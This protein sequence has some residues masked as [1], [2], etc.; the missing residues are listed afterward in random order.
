[1]AIPKSTRPRVRARKRVGRC[2]ELSFAVLMDHEDWTLVHGIVNG[3]PDECPRTCHAWLERD[4]QVFDPVSDELSPS[5]RYRI[6][7]DALAVARY[8]AHQAG[9]LA[10]ETRH[11]G[12]W[13]PEL[14]TFADQAERE[15]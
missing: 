4:G 8:S 7:F 13:H 3:P 10:L 14:L 12:P 1:M 9:G 5:L 11:Y 15:V 6:R 2:F